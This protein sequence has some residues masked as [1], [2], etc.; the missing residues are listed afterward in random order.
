MIKLE[1]YTVDPYPPE[2]R[3]VKI[4]APMHRKAVNQAAHSAAV[5]FEIVKREEWI[6]SLTDALNNGASFAEMQERIA[7]LAS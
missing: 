7:K 6:Q 1:P 3:I 4:L 5:R 2:Q